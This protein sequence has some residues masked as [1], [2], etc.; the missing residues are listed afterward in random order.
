[1]ITSTENFTTLTGFASGQVA[2]A[3]TLSKPTNRLKLELNELNIALKLLM[4]DNSPVPTWVTES[5]EQ[6][7]IVKH[8]NIVW[9]SLKTTSVEPGT[10]ITAWA[11]MSSVVD[12]FTELVS[13]PGFDN[14]VPKTG[15]VMSGP[16]IS[17]REKKIAVTT[18]NIDLSLGNLFTKTISANTAFTVS[19]VPTTGQASIFVLELTNDASSAITW[20]P[21]IKWTSGVAPALTSK[22]V[23]VLTFYTYDAGVTWRGILSSK[24]S[25]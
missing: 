2:S 10:D 9:K 1:M 17:L 15:T 11:D 25:K 19:N 24:D 18:N 8:N 21:G 20:W 22:G 6:D 3:D 4:G 5:Y 7:S 12:T 16:I 14:Y 13:G 23:D